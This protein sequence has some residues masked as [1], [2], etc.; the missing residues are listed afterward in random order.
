VVTYQLQEASGVRDGS[1]STDWNLRD[2]I[3]NRSNDRMATICFDYADMQSRARLW[4]ANG[5]LLWEKVEEWPSHLHVSPAFSEDG[6][7]LG[8]Y[9]NQRVTVLD[10][11][12]ARV[13]NTCV[14]SNDE[15]ITAIA[16][17]RGGMGL[18]VVIAR[19]TGD[20]VSSEEGD[21]EYDDAMALAR[22]ESYTRL[23]RESYPAGDTTR[24]VHVL[25]TT[26]S[27]HQ[28][29]IAFSNHRTLL[30]TGSLKSMR[31]RDNHWGCWDIPTRSLHTA[32]I[33]PNE[34]CFLDGPL[35][36]SVLAGLDVGSFRAI[37]PGAYFGSTLF[38]RLLDGRKMMT[39]TAR[40]LAC[41]VTPAGSLLMLEDDTLMQGLEEL[42]PEINDA[43]SA[44]RYIW[45]WDGNGNAKMVGKLV[46]NNLPPVRQIKAFARTREGLVLMVDNERF[47]LFKTLRE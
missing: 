12:E 5:D 41:G 11:Q 37:W 32:L 22:V 42:Q 8:L 35:V 4:N 21:D 44:R 20:I 31:S 30:F 43:S 24:F 2:V 25:S 23:T 7:F 17:A 27:M 36:T 47:M 29:A 1:E 3:V 38:V 28:T 18:A 19:S 40:S 45:K 26:H 33:K 46:G 13:A 16:I 14:F 6:R 9:A 34:H 15:T 10:A 39:F